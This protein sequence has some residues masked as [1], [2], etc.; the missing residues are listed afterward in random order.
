M[1]IQPFELIIILNKMKSQKSIEDFEVENDKISIYLIPSKEQ[2][3][4]ENKW[5]GQNIKDAWY[6][7]KKLFGDC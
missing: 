2:N 5:F 3:D 6:N 7:I 4:R 1:K